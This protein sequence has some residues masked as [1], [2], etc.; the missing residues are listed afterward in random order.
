MDVMLLVQGTLCIYSAPAALTAA[1][2]VGALASLMY[3]LQVVS[4]LLVAMSYV[5][6]SDAFHT[7]DIL[8][9]WYVACTNHQQHEGHAPLGWL[10]TTTVGG[11][12]RAQAVDNTSTCSMRMITSRYC[13]DQL[14]AVQPLRHCAGWC[15]V[16]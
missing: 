8:E 2:N 3:G 16:C 12:G 14:P 4:G 1:Y 9:G 5:A 6:S 15:S 11:H 13:E 10:C 7:L